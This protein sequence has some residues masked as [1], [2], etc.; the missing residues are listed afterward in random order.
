MQVLTN[1]MVL[2]RRPVNWQEKFAF[3]DQK[4][5]VEGWSRNEPETMQT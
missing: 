1:V 3:A 4:V 5:G 2:I